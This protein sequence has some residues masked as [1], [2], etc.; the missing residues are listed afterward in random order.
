M[1]LISVNNLFSYR[2][3]YKSFIKEMLKNTSTVFRQ[4]SGLACVL[5]NLATEASLKITTA[6]EEIPSSTQDLEW[7]SARPYNEIPRQSKYDFIRSYLPGGRFRNTSATETALTLKKELGELFVVPGIFRRSDILM[8]LNPDHIEKIY[9]TEGIWPGRDGFE[10]VAYFRNVLKKDFFGDTSGLIVAQGESWGRQRSAVN[11]VIVQPRNVK[12]YIKSLIDVNDEFVQRIRD[13]RDPS[14]F[15][16]PGS[17]EEDLN[18]LTFESITSIALNQNF[19]LVRREKEHP[20]ALRMFKNVRDFFIYIYE[21]E[22]KPSMW[23]MVRTPMF[24]KMMNCQEE[25]FE[26]TNKFVTDAM[27]ELERKKSLG[28]SSENQEPSVLEKLLKI[29]KKVAIVMTMDM[30]LAGVDVTSTVLAGLLL[31]LAKNPAKQDIL[32]EEVF[33]IL[34]HKDSPLSV[35]SMKNMPYLRAC[36]KESMRFYPVAAGSFRTAGR[37]IVLGGYQVPKGTNAI[38]NSFLMLLD[39][40]YYSRPNEFIPERWLRKN[41]NSSEIIQDNSHPFSFLPF[42]FGPRICVG[43]RIVDIELEVCM[44][45]LIRNFK[46]EYNHPAENAFK[47]YF[48]NIPAIPLNFKFTDINV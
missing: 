37:D 41:S 8:V 14:T 6:T 46:I 5:R 15:E 27:N 3:V 11:P 23:K 18:R 45:K 13:V 42:G 20:E 17:F 30:L 34:P 31:T 12:L 43:K 4:K 29:D 44:A 19:G 40:N 48:V 36:I 22:M 9:R 47:Q 26:T 32:R 39:E 33:K 10:T 16:V 1:E 21:L 7:V 38:T 25:I 2:T 24:N 35:E 28:I